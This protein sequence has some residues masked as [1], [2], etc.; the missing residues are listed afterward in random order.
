VASVA[1]LVEREGLRERAGEYLERA[2]QVLREHDR[3]RLIEFGPTRV[4]AE[5]DDD[6]TRLV[7]LESASGGLRSACDC[8]AQTTNG[9]CPHVVAAAIETWHRAPDR[10]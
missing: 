7:V 5:V 8:G 2:G 6:G 9:L 4:T 1:D 10:R 3:V